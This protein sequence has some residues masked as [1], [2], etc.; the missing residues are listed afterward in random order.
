MPPRS[1]WPPTLRPPPSP[2]P[3]LPRPTPSPARSTCPSAPFPDRSSSG[4]ARPTRSSTRGTS[5]GRRARRPTSIPSWPPKCSRAPTGPCAP[6]SEDQ[7]AP[8]PPSSRV[9]R[10]RPPQAAWQPSSVAARAELGERVDLVNESD[11]KRGWPVY[12]ASTEDELERSSRLG[13]R[14]PVTVPHRL[15]RGAA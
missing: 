2:T 11:R 4:Y 14:Q 13:G 8:L 15:G 5:P 12:L 10:R 7:G 1:S 3:R 6:T 9:P